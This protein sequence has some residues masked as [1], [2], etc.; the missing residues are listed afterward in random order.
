MQDMCGGETVAKRKTRS[1]TR[2]GVCYE[3]LTS[4]SLF[5]VSMA[6]AC[7]LSE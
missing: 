5:K 6:N 1:A 2:L 3:A 4:M 7:G